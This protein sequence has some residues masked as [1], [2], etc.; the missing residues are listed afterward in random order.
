MPESFG[1]KRVEHLA[2]IEKQVGIADGVITALSNFAKMPLP[3]RSPLA[4]R[5]LV[6]EVLDTVQ[7]PSAIHVELDLPAT[8]PR[9]L[10]DAGQLQ[11]VLANLIRN[12]SDAMSG[13]GTITISG[14]TEGDVVQVSVADTG[15]G[16][17]SG[18]IK[19]IMEPFFTTKA[20]GIGLGLA[21]SNA[22]LAKNDATLT[23]ESV[24]GQ[25]SVFTISLEAAPHEETV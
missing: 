22:I 18:D 24:V 4:V 21:I 15:H 8:L 20:R 19:R 2:R 16:I 14:R 23:V 6:Q 3:A 7:L 1:E 13:A 10:A 5:V 12:A 25:G 9:V 11:I 17:S